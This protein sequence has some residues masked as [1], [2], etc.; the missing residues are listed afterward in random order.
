MVTRSGSNHARRN[1]RTQAATTA[2]WNG[3][4]RTFFKSA[5]AP[6]A[7][8]V[9]DRDLTMRDELDSVLLGVD[10]DSIPRMPELSAEARTSG[11]EGKR[12]M[13]G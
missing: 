11:C 7:L 5:G 8:L 9:G 13:G 12:K 4:P 10:S 6:E 1:K 2:R 3:A